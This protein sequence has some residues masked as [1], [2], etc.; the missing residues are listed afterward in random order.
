ME[1]LERY[2]TLGRPGL[3]RAGR[4]HAG[5]V[6]ECAGEC[7]DAAVGLG[8]GAGFERRRD[9]RLVRICCGIVARRIWWSMGRI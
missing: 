3:V 5:A 7:A 4:V 6:F 8:D 9:V 1:A 2:L